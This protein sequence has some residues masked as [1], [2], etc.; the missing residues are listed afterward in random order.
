MQ[1]SWGHEYPWKL[2]VVHGPRGLPN[3]AEGH[4]FGVVCLQAKVVMHTNNDNDCN[5]RGKDNDKLMNKGRPQ[6]P[7]AQ[8]TPGALCRSS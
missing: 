2:Q 3:D 1:L 4:R 6:A 5:N 8:G 7:R